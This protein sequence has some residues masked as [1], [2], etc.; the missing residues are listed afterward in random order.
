MRK[1]AI[2]LDFFGTV[3]HEDHKIIPGICAR[4][5]K[6]AQV[7]EKEVYQFWARRFGALLAESFGERFRLHREVELVSLRDTLAY[8]KLDT[9][10][11]ELSQ[12]L[13]EHWMKPPL[14]DDARLFLQALDI[15]VCVVSNID[16]S[17]LLQ[18]IS[19]HDLQVDYVV[20]SEDARAYKPRTEI[21]QLALQELDVLPQDVL[22]IGD[23]LT[24]D[25]L[26]AKGVGISTAWVNRKQRE[27]HPGITPDIV[28]NNLLDLLDWGLGRR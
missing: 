20:T 1:A 17:D 10:P 9:D 5:S 14:Y 6:D 19:Y 4:I 12:P 25:V 22:H 16:R 23:S 15:P 21:F 26:G 8:F 27:P 28:C 2:M 3:V 7:T 24:N 11:A 13:Y 18:A